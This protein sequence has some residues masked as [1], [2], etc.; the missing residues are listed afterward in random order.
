[1]EPEFSE[2]LISKGYEI[3]TS[4]DKSSIETFFSNL[5]PSQESIRSQSYLLLNCCKKHHA[6]LLFLKLYYIL[7]FSTSFEMR[8]N[9]ITTLRYIKVEELWPSLSKTARENL[10]K[11]FLYCLDQEKHM[12]NLRSLCHIVSDMT[13]AIYKADDRWQELIDFLGNEKVGEA[14]LLVITN[15]PQDCKLFYDQ[16]L[17]SS[18]EYLHKGLLKALT[19]SNVDV[20]VVASSTL[21]NLVCLYSNNSKQELFFQLLDAISGSIFGFIKNSQEYNAQR[22]ITQLLVL[23]THDRNT[24]ILSSYLEFSLLN[25]IL[26][27][28][29]ALI[30]EKITYSIIHFLIN[31]A[32][33]K[34]LHPVLRG[35]QDE[36]VLRLLNISVRLMFYIED[37]ISWEQKIDE[38]IEDERKSFYASGVECLTQFTIAFGETKIVLNAFKLFPM[39]MESQDWEKRHAAIKTL[40]IIAQ[41]CSDEMV[42]SRN[43]M[44]QGINMVLKF[45]RDPHPRV[46]YATFKFMQLRIDFV[47]AIQI[48]HHIRILPAFVVSLNENHI[49]KVKEEVIAAMLYFIKNTIPNISIMHIDVDELLINLLTYFQ[50]TNVTTKGSMNALSLIN[51]LT[52]YCIDF[53]WKHLPHYIAILLEASTHENLEIKQEAVCGIGICAQFGGLQF[54]PFLTKAIQNLGN[55]LIKSYQSQAKDS[56]FHG[57]ILLVIGKI[58]EFHSSCLD[59][60]KLVSILLKHL[61]LKDN[62]I[63]AKRLHEQLCSLAKK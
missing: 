21:R 7:R 17:I 25:M 16:G 29:Y 58:L 28:E 18:L 10:K 15:L 61:P 60:N 27:M 54:Q 4:S 41:E 56:K 38:D 46:C 5:L 62:S 37:D 11:D 44:E 59:S 52:Q 50:S 20:Q 33:T 55:L 48:F 3:L 1:M 39:F 8:S 40:A 47:Q 13:C 32:K 26:I 36:M 12:L 30:K 49:I 19:S 57:I 22:I 45:I 23:I 35:L 24:Q 43:F 6:S 53:V 14:P 51:I 31:V 9:S 42:M 2:Q 63:E 34:K